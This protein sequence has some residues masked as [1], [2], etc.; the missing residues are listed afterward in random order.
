[1]LFELA[2]GEREGDLV[3]IAGPRTEQIA[4]LARKVVARRGE[5]LTVVARE[6]F[7]PIKNGALLPGPGA[8]IAGPT[9]D[10]WLAA[11]SA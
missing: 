2:T 10:E 7:E 9:F 1:M 8:V 3:E 11:Q 5:D 6:A 4:E